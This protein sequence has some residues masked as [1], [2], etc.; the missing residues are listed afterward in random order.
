MN[1]FKNLLIETKFISMTKIMDYLLRDDDVKNIISD[2][3][4]HINADDEV[5]TVQ[6]FVKEILSEEDEVTPK[7]IKGSSTVIFTP[8]ADNYRNCITAITRAEKVKVDDLNAID[9]FAIFISLANIGDVE[10]CFDEVGIERLELLTYILA[11]IPENNRH[12][13]TEKTLSPEVKY[14][15]KKAK[16]SSVEDS[17]APQT[18]EEVL[19]ELEEFPFLT[20][21]IEQAKSYSLPFIGREDVIERTI[22]ILN[23]KLKHNVMHIGEPGVGKTACTIGLAKKILADEVPPVLKN[24]KVF[25]LD[26]GS[27]MAGTKYRGE[28]EQKITDALSVLGKLD[29][30]VLYIDEVH[31]IVGAGSTEASSI[32]VANLLKPYLSSADTNIRVIGSTTKEEYKKHIEKDKAFCRRFQIVEIN[33]PSI[34][35]AKSILMGLKSSFETYHKVTYT[36]EA[37]A[38]AVELSAKYIN[39]KFLPDKAIDVIDETASRLSIAGQK[40]VQKTDIQATVSKIAKIPSED[41]NET[42]TEKL[43][44]LESSLSKNVFGQEEAINNIVAAINMSK[45]GLNE[46]NKPIASFLFVGPTGVGKTEVA[47]TLSN[48]LGIP[49]V[50]FDMSEYK[51]STSVNKF[52]GASAGYVG[53]EDG[54]LL[55]NAIKDKP[56]CVL[57]LDEI[58]KAHPAVFDVLLQVMDNATLTDNKGNVA[59]FRNVVIIM[60]SNAGARDISKSSIGFG[61]NG[62][63][64]V[65]ISAMDDAV[66]ATFSPEF[67][68]RLTSVVKFNGMSN[69][70]AREIAIKQLNILASKLSSKKI[71]IKYNDAV[72]DAIVSKATSVDM[73]G[74]EIIRVVDKQVKPLFVEEILFGSLVNGGSATIFV[75]ND[76]F[77]IKCS[78]KSKKTVKTPAAV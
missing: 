56:S 51:D 6:N 46:D 35:E 8:N 26:I 59:D 17:S 3:L 62:K 32:D 19:K 63:E 29:K 39:D 53:Y 55:V 52:I 45:A 54:G 23:R 2:F 78:E 30:V 61:H 24:A 58:E 16:K 13:F 18:E 5:D 34:E 21:M 12:V 77:A 15:L 67:R 14:I 50:R 73:G 69:E 22:M 48:T 44:K 57:L 76:K 38:T 25:S 27:M 64:T 42:E 11:K 41:V 66:K 9:Y 4:K 36:K 47:K 65:N 72:V 20:N 31:L 1:I 43:S 60:T 33:E 71:K 37:I 74:R 10:F 40:K 75:D 68:N 7:E 49:L 70:M 28:L